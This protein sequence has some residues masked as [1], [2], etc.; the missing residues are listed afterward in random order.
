MNDRIRYFVFFISLRIEDVALN[1]KPIFDVWFA[2][3]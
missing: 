2:C 3:E 1:P